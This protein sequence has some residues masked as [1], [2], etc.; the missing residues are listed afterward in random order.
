MKNVWRGMM[1]GAGTGAVIGMVLDASHRA[2]RKAADTADKAA[3]VVKEK[4]RQ[5]LNAARDAVS[6]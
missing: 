6:D 1:V 5:G 2:G 3:H 4:A